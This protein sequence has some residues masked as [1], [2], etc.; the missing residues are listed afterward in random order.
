MVGMQRVR[1][2]LDYLLFP[3]DAELGRDD[4]LQ[5]RAPAVGGESNALLLLCSEEPLGQLKASLTANIHLQ[6]VDPARLNQVPERRL[7]RFVLSRRE[8][9]GLAD[10]E[11]LVR[12]LIVGRQGLRDSTEIGWREVSAEVL[13][14]LGRVP[15]DVHA[16]RIV[17]VEHHPEL[18][19]LHSPHRCRNLGSPSR[20]VP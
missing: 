18:R 16:A 19:P 11:R 10:V 15:P 7:V 9:H 20:P 2:P 1:E 8:P 12:S 17:E 13:D 14:G 4:C 5:Q 6:E 3:A